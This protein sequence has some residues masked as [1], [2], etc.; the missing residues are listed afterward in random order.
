MANDFL[1]NGTIVVIT[2]TGDICQITKLI[3]PGTYR[4]KPTVVLYDIATNHVFSDEFTIGTSEDVYEFQLIQMPY[5]ELKREWA[6]MMDRIAEGETEEQVGFHL[7]L[8]KVA[9][10]RNIDEWDL[11]NED[12]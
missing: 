12:E 9:R 7:R 10:L 6:T 1:Q 2:E 3:Y 8:K 5:Y 4:I 11:E